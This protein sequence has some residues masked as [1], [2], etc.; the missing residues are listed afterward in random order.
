M[1]SFSANSS[2]LG[3]RPISLSNRW[4]VRTILLMMSIMCTAV[5]RVIACR[6]HQVA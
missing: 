1:P 6:I 2:G 4:D 5:E 3:S